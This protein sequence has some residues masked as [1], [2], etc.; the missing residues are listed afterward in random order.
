LPSAIIGRNNFDGLTT[1]M[2]FYNKILKN[3]IP[4]DPN[5]SFNVVDVND[6][7]KGAILASTKGRNGERY[8][9]A[10]PPTIS[11]KRMFEIANQ[12]NLNVKIKRQNRRNLCFLWQVWLKW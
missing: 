9:L 11:T 7:A 2:E 3:K 10:T 6:V 8:V 1:T 5:F 12:V 4:F